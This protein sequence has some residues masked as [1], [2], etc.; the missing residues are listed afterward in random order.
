MRR[1]W[2]EVGMPIELKPWRLDPVTFEECLQYVCNEKLARVIIPRQLPELDKLVN[3][4]CYIQGSYLVTGYRGVGK[5]SFVNYVLAMAH[6]QSVEQEPPCILVPIFLNLAR[7]YDVGKLLRRT[8]RQLYRTLAETKV[9][10]KDTAQSVSL[11]SRLPHDLQKELNTAYLKTSAKV[12]EATTEALKTVIAQETTREFTIGGEASGEYSLLPNPLPAK[13]GAKLAGGYSRSRTLSKSEEIAKETVDSLEYLEYDD[14]IAEDELSRLIGRLTLSP[15]ELQYSEKQPIS[16]RFSRFWKLWGKI[17]HRDYFSRTVLQQETRRLQLVFVYDELDKV[18]PQEAQKMLST[19]KPVLI[20]SQATFIFVGG[21]EF[22]NQWLAR[23]QPEGDSLYSLFTDVIYIPLYD[24]DEIESFAQ[25]L[26]ESHSDGDIAA[27]QLDHL[28]LHCGGTLRGFFQQVFPLVQ[29][30][31]YKPALCD[32]D[33]NDLYA[34]TSDHVRTINDQISKEHPPQIRDALKRL[35]YTWL[36]TAEKEQRFTR[37][38]LYDPTRVQRDSLGHRWELAVAAHFEIFWAE[39]L[40]N[41]VFKATESASEWYEFSSE[42]S[43]GN[44]IHFESVDVLVP[45]GDSKPEVS[46]G[47]MPQPFPD[48]AIIPP[49]GPLPPGSR[50]PFV[51]NKNFVGREE[52]LRAVAGALLQPSQSAVLIPQLISGMGGIGK[53]Q[54]AIEFAYRYGRFFKGVHWLNA[55]NP[56]SIEAEIAA[57]GLAQGVTLWPETLSKQVTVTLRT[58]AMDGPRLVI[59]DDLEDEVAAEK[60]LPEL[61]N[62]AAHLLITSRGAKWARVLN[63]NQ[64]TLS[65]LSSNIGLRLLR[66]IFGNVRTGDS[67]DELSILMDRL[68]HLPL[69]LELAARYLLAHPKLSIPAYLARLQITDLNPLQ[70]TFDTSWN[71]LSDEKAQQVL[72]IMAYC[73]PGVPIPAGLLRQASGIEDLKTFDIAL[74]QLTNNAFIQTDSTQLP[75]IH[76]LVA[77]YVRLKVPKEQRMVFLKSLM[78]AL[79]ESSTLAL[80]SG[81][82]GNFAPL[83]LHLETALC[84]LEQER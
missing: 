69:P 40:E 48:P 41:G 83:R 2:W 84:L 13:V 4:I 76:P 68:G 38:Q 10:V 71:Q 1:R 70:A 66:D 55:R 51:H 63:L 3:H 8:I 11:Y 79:E 44:W 57:C 62:N 7:S 29:W 12:S 24:D 32:S 72:G 78:D 46:V 80:Q 19:L 18:E 34:K 28:R 33:V 36:M 37:Q 5:S 14:E 6:K 64:L 81:R 43:L 22:A 53:T 17:W 20:S 58:W 47:Y 23:T 65:G 61:V 42:F 31:T 77:E 67:D 25:A 26:V 49:P 45:P 16:H 21:Y 60:W 74:S 82:P 56:E 59:L 35:T 30:D 73:A 75:I 50:V 39:V 27:L 9:R 54:F 15:I 52:Q